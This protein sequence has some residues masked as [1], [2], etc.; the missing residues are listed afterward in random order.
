MTNIPSSESN[1]RSRK[2]I[3]IEVS[4]AVPPVE[5]DPVFLDEAVTNVARERPQVHAAGDARSAIAAR[6]CRRR[7]ACGSRSRTADRASRTR[8]CR[9]CSRSSIACRARR[10]LASGHRDRPRGRRGAWSRRWAAGS[11]AR[12]S[13]LG[14]LAIDID[15]PL[16]RPP[17]RV[18]IERGRVTATPPGGRTGAD[19]PRRRGRRRDACRARPRAGRARLPRRSRPPT[20]AT[21]LERWERRRPDV[22]LLDLG[23]PDM[24]GLERH[25]PDPARRDDADRD[26]VRPLRG[27]REGRGARARRRRLRDQ[28]V[29]R[30]RAQRPPARRAPPR[31]RARPPT[32]TAGSSA[33]PLD[34]R[35]R[36]P[37]GARRRRAAST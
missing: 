13:E 16:A 19:G 20:A 31:R 6:R 29:R 35:R 26:P 2:T 22:V 7:H 37:R 27:A 21:A 18:P 5:V 17:R 15:L 3:P 33:G 8:A 12:R 11:T 1:L 10:R 4:L 30:R 25:P 24:D 14:G 34:V 28:A 23:L 36:A 9:S 32:P